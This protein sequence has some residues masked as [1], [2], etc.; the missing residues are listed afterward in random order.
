MRFVNRL[1]AM[2]LAL[3]LVAAAV[4]VGI[5]SVARY[6]GN[7]AVLLPLETWSTTLEQTSWDTD[8]WLVAAVAAVALG[9]ITM[10]AQILPRRRRTVARKDDSQTRTVTYSRSGVADRLRDV[11]IDQPG[12]L[13]ADV[14][15]GGRKVRI[16]AST[17]TGARPDEPAASVRRAVSDELDS[18]DLARRP[19]VKVHVGNARDRV[20]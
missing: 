17:P 7:E 19:K 16:E 4:V 15:V 8:A 1:L 11:A 9:V 6:T 20:L 5:E 2:I 3:A 18:L 12:V 13:D 10:I 14:K